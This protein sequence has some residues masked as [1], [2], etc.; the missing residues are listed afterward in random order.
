MTNSWSKHHSLLK[1]QASE[2]HGSDFKISILKIG[3]ISCYFDDLIL[4]LSFFDTS[5]I[6]TRSCFS[7]SLTNSVLRVASDSVE[8][9][10]FMVS[11]VSTFKRCIFILMVSILGVFGVYY[12]ESSFTAL[13]HM[14]LCGLDLW[15]KHLYTWSLS[16]CE[17]R[18]RVYMKFLHAGRSWQHLYEPPFL[19]YRF[20]QPIKILSHLMVLISRHKIA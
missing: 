5:F 9:S 1:A 6:K 18:Q 3:R 14:H 12:H 16:L 8:R 17:F 4:P 11:E 20:F 10:R 2:N 19:I 7:R 15:R 13:L